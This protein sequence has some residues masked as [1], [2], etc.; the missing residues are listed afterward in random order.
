[1]KHRIRILTSIFFLISTLCTAQK[2]DVQ[3]ARLLNKMEKFFI[4]TLTDNYGF[5]KD[6][7]LLRIFFE[8]FYRNDG[9]YFLEINRKKIAS[10]NEELFQDSA[11]FYFYVEKIFVSTRDS[12][13]LLHDK[14]NE[15]GK[16]DFL[17]DFKQPAYR[18]TI[19][20]PKYSVALNEKFLR[21]QV[22]V[23]GHQSQILAQIEKL[24]D[25]KGK[26][27]NMFDFIELALT[28]PEELTKPELKTLSTLV[29]WKYLCYCTNYDLNRRTKKGKYEI[30]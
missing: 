19:A 14:L 3:N 23:E 12:V 15:S 29:F 13:A 2:Y 25:A 30:N 26:E 8:N 6:D 20:D 22:F 4:Q 11:F 17:V 1:M 5:N 7:I 27:Q 9:E 18:G 28:K 16:S 24:W 10:L 21:S